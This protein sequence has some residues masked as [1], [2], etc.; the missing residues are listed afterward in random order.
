VFAVSDNA[1]NGLKVAG[2]PIPLIAHKIKTRR[3]TLAE[4]A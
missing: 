3:F 4:I 2:T 1:H